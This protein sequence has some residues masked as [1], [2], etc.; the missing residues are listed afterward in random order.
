M[1]SEPIPEPDDFDLLALAGDDWLEARMEEVRKIAS[2]V[3]A[4]YREKLENADPLMRIYLRREID[5]RVLMRVSE[6]ESG[7]GPIE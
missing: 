2:E 4:G 7:Q 3:E 5:Q 6:M 1:H